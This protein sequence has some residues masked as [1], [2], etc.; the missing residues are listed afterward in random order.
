MAF[1][2]TCGH[3]QGRLLIETAGVTV[4]CPHCGAHI[5]ADDPAANDSVAPADIP[6]DAPAEPAPAAV[7]EVSPSAVAMAESKSDDA[8]PSGP[9]SADAAMSLD[10]PD[11][12]GLSAHE[13]AP[14]AGFPSFR[15][16]AIALS[17]SDV[18]FPALDASPAGA[19]TQTAP[20][21]GSNSS[22]AK[23]NSK[24]E[25]KQSE[26][27]ST[28]KGEY[29]TA[30]GRRSAPT[31]PMSWFIIV[32]GLASALLMAC[33]ILVA[34][35]SAAKPHDLESLPDVKPDL[36]PTG[37]INRELYDHMVRIPP[38]HTLSLKERDAVRLGNLRI[39]PLEVTR[40]PLVFTHYR[41][42]RTE[43]TPRPV[44]KLWLR[45]K[46]VSDKQAFVPLDADL[47]WGQAQYVDGIRRGNTFVSTVADKGNPSR[48]VPAYLHSPD[49]ES[50]PKDMPVG[51]KLAPGEEMKI[52]IPSEENGIDKLH[53]PLVWR[54]HLRKG[55][56]PKSGRGVT[57][58]VEVAFD[59]SDIR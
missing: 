49:L 46:N 33:I 31:V 18:A 59:S 41:N 57:T 8:P 34:S 20:R 50:Q 42:N 28:D 55:H 19:A 5:T 16:S 58:L 1:E 21:P 30:G 43:R 3:C 14:P 23:S 25:P 4:A 40:E 9:P 22:A 7:P 2:A 56:N 17:S 45:L 53:G 24:G 38:G 27:K 52:Y 54:V 12:T 51:H 47:L 32:A 48:H 39:E 10:Y 6:V 15:D 35:R 26:A 11:F 36:A 37:Q 44:L 13:D 29:A